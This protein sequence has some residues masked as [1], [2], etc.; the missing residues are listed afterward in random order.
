MASYTAQHGDSLWSIAAA[1]KPT[2][3]STGEYWTKLKAANQGVKLF[4]GT[5]VNLPSV[6]DASNAPGSNRSVVVAKSD[7]RNAPGSNMSPAPKPDS[8][9]APGSN[10]SPVVTKADSRNAPGSNTFT[11]PVVK[12][13]SRNAPG[14]NVDNTPNAA[15][16]PQRAAAEMMKRSPQRANAALAAALAAKALGKKK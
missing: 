6:A 7:S 8:R 14:S 13:D 4:R 11:R 3:M 9:N 10:K 1:N 16:S 2:S 12:S 5:K 15:R